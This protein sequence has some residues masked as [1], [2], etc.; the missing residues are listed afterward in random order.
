MAQYEISVSLVNETKGH[1]FSDWQ[2]EEVPLKD[3]G[4]PDFGAIYHA[5][6][7]EF[8]RCQSSVYVDTDGPPKKIGWYFVKRAQYDGDSWT[9]LQGAWVTVRELVEP[10]TP[11]RYAYAEVG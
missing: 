9:Y 11:A 5:Y 7:R 2:D 10:A 8:G 4:L 1:R 3:S 6:Q